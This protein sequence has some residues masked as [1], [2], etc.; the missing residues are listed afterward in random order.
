MFMLCFALFLIL[1][2]INLSFVS[3]GVYLSSLDNVYN[4]GDL[5]DLNI[6]V[7]ASG[8]GPLKLKLVCDGNSVDVFNGPVI[9]N[10]VVPLTPDWI[11]NL[12][13]DC[14]FQADYNGDT[15]RTNPLFK[16]SRDLGI[17]LDIESFV[18]KPGER[19]TISGVVKKLNGAGSNG[20]IEINAPFLQPTGSNTGL[21]NS[22]DNSTNSTNVNSALTGV[23]SG[24]VSDGIFSVD[25]VI[26]EK[27]ASGDFQLDISSYEKSDKGEIINKGTAT[28]KLIVPQVLTNIDVALNNQNF[29]PGENISFKPVLLDQTGAVIMDQLTILVFTKDGERIFERVVQSEESVSFEIPTALPSA[30]YTVE[31]SSRNLSSTKTFFVNEKA[32]ANF[33]I[34]NNTLI[35]TNIGNI[36]YT[37]DV[38]VE[39]NGKPFVQKL[40]LDLGEKKEFKLTGTEGSYDIKVSD[41]ENELKQSGVSLTGFAIGVEDPDAKSSVLSSAVLYTPVFWI[42]LIIILAAALLFLFREV[43]KRKSFAYPS[44]GMRSG[45]VTSNTVLKLQHIGKDSEDRKNIEKKEEKKEVKVAK[46]SSLVIGAAPRI[47]EQAMVTNGERNRATIISLKIKNRIGSEAKKSLESAVQPIYSRK[48]AICEQGDYLLMILSPLVTK[49]FNNEVEASKVSEQIVSALKEYNAKFKDKIEFG[50][51]IHNGEIL[52]EVREGKLKFTAIGNT[53]LVAKKIA[54]ISKGEILMSKEAYEKAGSAIK[55]ERK[56]INDQEFYEIKNIVDHEK[57]KKFIDDFMKRNAMEK[58][59][60]FSSGSGNNKGFGADPNSIQ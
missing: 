34:V 43:L 44:S 28:A 42:I 26:P 4:M 23:F 16:I 11:G 8:S 32:I 6:S 39:L 52:N 30:Y 41:G 51:A 17:G 33:E 18:A 50:I 40:D 20:E 54:E 27:M 22:S 38:Q 53:V 3:A 49:T 46:L 13:G 5:I 37:K 45:N 56:K 29:N 21:N 57:S 48:G 7:D 19:I 55:A 60:S 36:R 14:Y 35:I 1:S 31:F 47:A 10:I 24:K 58:R 12:K 2:I 59:R 15:K 9:E 25:I